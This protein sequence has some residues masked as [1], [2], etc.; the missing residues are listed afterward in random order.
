MII[1]NYY[2]RIIGG[3]GKMDNELKQQLDWI[4]SNLN[5]IVKNQSMLYAELHKIEQSM[6]QPEEEPVE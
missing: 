1:R 2:T 4:N 3:I 6:K 5:A